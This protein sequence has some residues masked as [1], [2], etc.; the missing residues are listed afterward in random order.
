MSYP[1]ALPHS[2]FLSPR[3]PCSRCRLR[4]VCRAWR[5]FL[6]KQ[7]RLRTARSRRR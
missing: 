6:S 5:N 4:R 7:S 1:T 2:R 3:P